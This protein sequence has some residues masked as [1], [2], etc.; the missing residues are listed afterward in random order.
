[1]YA[2]SYPQIAIDQENCWIQ[3]AKANP[4]NFGPLYKKYYKKIFTYIDRRIQNKDVSSDIASQVFINAIQRIHTYE[5]KGY[6]FG[7][8]LYRI[9]HNEIC[10]E[11]RNAQKNRMVS[12]EES[13]F[14]LVDEKEDTVEKE[15]ALILLESVLT[16]L[17][18]KHLQILTLRYFEN[19]SFKE[20]GDTL[21]ITENSAKVRCFRA[22]EKLKEV[23]KK[24][25]YTH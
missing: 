25:V 24:S 17:K 1:M 3:E 22:L 10:Q 2:L 8:W 15:A 18:K 4:M 7:S 19:R 11:Y 20:I 14:Q 9:A 21:S 16:N 6:S 5:Y 23:Y 12:L 13:P